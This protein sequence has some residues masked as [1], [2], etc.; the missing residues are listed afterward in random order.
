MEETIKV[1]VKFANSQQESEEYT[2]REILVIYRKSRQN[3][4]KINLA[5]IFSFPSKII[6][7][8]IYKKEKDKKNYSE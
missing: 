2:S 3:Q 1:V 5:I 4:Y 6:Y 8:I 7:I